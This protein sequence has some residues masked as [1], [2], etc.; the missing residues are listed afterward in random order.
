MIHIFFFILDIYLG[1]IKSSKEHYKNILHIILIRACTVLFDQFN[2]SLLYKSINTLLSN[3]RA[4]NETVNVKLTLISCLLSFS[5]CE[6]KHICIDFATLLLPALNNVFMCS[7]MLMAHSLEDHF[8]PHSHGY[9]PERERES[10]RMRLYILHIVCV[11]VCVCACTLCT[12]TLINYLI[13]T[14]P[15][16]RIWGYGNYH[17]I[18]ILTYKEKSRGSIRRWDELEYLHDFLMLISAFQWEC[19]INCGFWSRYMGPTKRKVL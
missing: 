3:T 9:Y 6:V 4:E 8:K 15:C 13:E 12:V 18:N 1:W 10:N 7:K 17:P 14:L 5:W 16:T 19:L 2:E 11:C